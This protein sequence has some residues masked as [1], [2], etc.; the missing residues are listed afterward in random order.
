M[1]TL[2]RPVSDQQGAAARWES[3]PDTGD[4]QHVPVLQAKDEGLPRV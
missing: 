2:W 4:Q 3:P 1:Q